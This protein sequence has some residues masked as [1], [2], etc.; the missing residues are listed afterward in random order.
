MSVPPTRDETSASQETAG[1]PLPGFRSQCVILEKK[2][3]TQSDAG[4]AEVW[5]DVCLSQGINE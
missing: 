2:Q 3:E 5:G 4:T 1:C